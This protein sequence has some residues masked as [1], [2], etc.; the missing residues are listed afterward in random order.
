MATNK[1]MP[2]T[3]RT[4]GAALLVCLLLTA[5]AALLGVTVLQGSVLQLKMADN[6]Q[7]AQAVFIAAE[8]G[9][10]YAER[11]LALHPLS[12]AQLHNAYCPTGAADCFEASCAGGLCFVGQHRGRQQDC[13]PYDATWDSEP[14]GWSRASL[15]WVA[16]N[17]HRTVPLEAEEDASIQFIIEFRCFV[18]GPQGAVAD[19]EGAAYYR[20]TVL[21]TGG[22]ATV[23]VMLQST[24]S[25]QWVTAGQSGRLWRHAWRAEG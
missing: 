3:N 2:N 8:H 12:T 18:D 17:K 14:I 9:L 25:V 21:A 13:T 6:A 24:V 10:R 7:Q 15:L 4:Q 20:I 1:I 19:D 16:A 23:Q 5:L 11:Y 22:A